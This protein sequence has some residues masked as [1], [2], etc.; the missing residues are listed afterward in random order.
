MPTHVL[1]VCTGNICRSPMA[2]VVLR[3]QLQ[4]RAVSIESAGLVAMSGNPIDPLAEAVLSAHGLSGRLHVARQI[5]PAII[6]AADLVLAMEKRH[7]SALHALSP[8]MRGRA[9]LLGKW[10][11]DAEIMDPYGRE[12]PAFERAYESMQ[13]ALSGWNT[14]F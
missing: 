4:G 2:E 12:R 7:L 5:N 13:A 10:Q 11:G 6:A 9:F 1:I 14:H 3:H 8:S